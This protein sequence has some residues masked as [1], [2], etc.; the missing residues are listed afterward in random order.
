MLF[1]SSLAGTRRGSG[2]G[3]S[4]ICLE[5][6]PSRPFGQLGGSVL[7]AEFAVAIVRERGLLTA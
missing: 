3:R 7:R 4:A 2:S 5:R 1:L 6:S